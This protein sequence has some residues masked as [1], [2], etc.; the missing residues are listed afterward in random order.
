MPLGTDYG[1]SEA[2]IAIALTEAM[3]GTM[4]N[5]GTLYGESEARLGIAIAE[6]FA[7]AGLGLGGSTPIPPIT[8][9]DQ[10][11]EARV[12]A[13]TNIALSG[14]PVI[15]TVGL[16]VGDRVLTTSQTNTAN[17]RLWTV[18]S[19]AWTPA[20]ALDETTELFQG[21]LVTV[22]EGSTQ[23]A[24]TT[25]VLATPNPQFGTPLTWKQQSVNATRL[26]GRNWS[27]VTPT[28]NQSPIYNAT[29]QTWTFANIV[30][31]GGP[32][33]GAAGGD[34][35]GTYP[36]PQIATGAIANADINAS[37]AIAES[38]LNLASDAAAATPSRRTLGTG[39][40]QATAGNDARLSDART[41]TAHTHPWNQVTA[42]PT[43]LSGYGITDAS[44]AG[45]LAAHAATTGNVA[46]I[47][48]DGIGTANVANDAITYAK[49]QNVSA[50]DRLLG[51]SSVGAG[52]VEEITCTAAGRALIDDADSSAQRSTLGLGT[53]DTPTFAAI[54]LGNRIFTGSLVP[55]SP[56]VGDLWWEQRTLP[57]FS[58]IWFW[59]GTYWLSAIPVHLGCTNNST[60]FSANTK[61]YLGT[62][63]FVT[64]FDFFIERANCTFTV[65]TTNNASNYWN[66]NLNYWSESSSSTVNINSINS[67]GVTVGATFSNNLY[68]GSGILLSQSSV[69]PRY[70]EIDL[71]KTGS[72]GNITKFT[73]S[74]QF[75]YARVPGV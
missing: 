63:V 23:Y 36:N 64:Q 69:L 52:D 3:L 33:T 58:T 75:R 10:V 1:I 50:T 2:R 21:L 51:R 31:S 24:N 12:V 15:D 18:A 29:T 14:T 13:V 49:L 56:N 68:N 19:G 4:T 60:T 22:L 65:A 72:P 44:G 5:L 37:A 30:G 38:K 67:I 40:L 35:S 9:I 20:S 39:A 7:A 46:H 42:T 32:P 73:A 55:S 59:N 16:Q 26:Q 17:N 57:F 48:S 41:P 74:L 61:I 28:N 8:A 27:N 43:T 34:L 53:T 47:P 54:N 25:W 11:L 6:A 71:S 70:F 66:I 62:T 45:D